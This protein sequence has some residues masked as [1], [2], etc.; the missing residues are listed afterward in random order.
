MQL[1]AIDCDKIITIV[2]VIINSDWIVLIFRR[3]TKTMRYNTIH[4]DLKY[5][6]IYLFVVVGRF[7]TLLI[8]GGGPVMMMLQYIFISIVI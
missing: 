7:L 5:I 3:Y 4:F 2:V 1:C 6:V 8:L